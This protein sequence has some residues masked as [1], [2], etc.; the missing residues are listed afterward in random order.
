MFSA[1]LWQLN[2]NQQSPPGEISSR[3]GT[4]VRQHRLPSDG[5]SKAR[6]GMFS[7]M[8]PKR[9]TNTAVN[10]VENLLLGIMVSH[11][12]VL[13]QSPKTFCQNR[14][15][16]TGGHPCQGVRFC[17]RRIHQGR[18]SSLASD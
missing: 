11:E 6:A 5:K 9:I 13:R 2:F 17:G 7:R 4:T 18:Q 12:I 15:Y 8:Y 3:D 1:G 10:E 16:P 14:E